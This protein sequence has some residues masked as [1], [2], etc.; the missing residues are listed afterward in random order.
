MLRL[1]IARNSIGDHSIQF[2]ERIALGCDT[3]AA[4]GIP[5]RHITAG[6]RAW[7]NVKDDLVLIAHNK[8][9]RGLEKESTGHLPKK[10]WTTPVRGIS[11]PAYICV[12]ARLLYRLSRKFP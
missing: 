5:A 12:G 7:F 9:I 10:R 1:E 2:S 11:S 4:G 3:A 6:N 8:K